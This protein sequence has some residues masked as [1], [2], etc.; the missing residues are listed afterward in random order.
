MGEE[1]MKELSSLMDAALTFAAAKIA[2][3]EHAEKALA[4]VAEQIRKPLRMR[5]ALPACCRSICCMGRPGRLYRTGKGKAWLSAKCSTRT[6]WQDAR[7][8]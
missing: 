5:L 8:H 7:Q 2:V 1:R 4:K 6:D 3:Q